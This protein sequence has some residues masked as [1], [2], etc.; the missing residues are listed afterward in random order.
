MDHVTLLTLASR[1]PRAITSSSCGQSLFAPASSTLTHQN[2]P[3][4][5]CEAASF[6]GPRLPS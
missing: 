2:Q 1:K 4:F 5:P 3:E 6:Y